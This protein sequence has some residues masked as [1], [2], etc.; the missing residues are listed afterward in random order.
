MAL[1]EIDRMARLVDDL[2]VL[3]RTD[4]A[5]FLALEQVDLEPFVLELFELVAATAGRRFELD[6]VPAGVLVADPERLAQALRNVLVNAVQHTR[7]GGLVRLEVTATAAGWVRFAVEDDGPGIPADQRDLV[8]ERFHRTDA[9]RARSTGG[10]GLG[11]AIVREIVVAH[12][13]KVT[14]GAT[15]GGRGGARLEL[16]LPGFT[17]HRS[18]PAEGASLG[19]ATRPGAGR[20][21]P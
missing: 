20:E 15:R 6:A 16:D 19:P 3:A 2:L 9:S 5:R 8:F 7:S 17:P 12:G 1:G 4:E 10:S 21:G 11:L 18:G 13:G 14:A